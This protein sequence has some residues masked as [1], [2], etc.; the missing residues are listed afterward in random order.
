MDWFCDHPLITRNK[1]TQTHHTSTEHTHNGSHTKFLFNLWFFSLS[2]LSYL[3]HSHWTGSIRLSPHEAKNCATVWFRAF[4]CLVVFLVP[5][6]MSARLQQSQHFYISI[7]CV[8]YKYFYVIAVPRTAGDFCFFLGDN[9]DKR[10]TRISVCLS[11]TILRS[12]TKRSHKK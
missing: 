10:I 2:I 9:R 4:L 1:H 6:S 7:A 11:K 8:H 3:W 12:I 5:W